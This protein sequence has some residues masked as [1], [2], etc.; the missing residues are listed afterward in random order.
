LEVLKILTLCIASAVTYGIIHDLVTVQICPE[1]FTVAHPPIFQTASLV[2]LAFFWGIAAT[3]WV[4]AILGVILAFAARM[5]RWTKRNARSLIKP[6]WAL[7]LSTGLAA[8]GFGFL[9]WLL[10]SLGL[11]QLAGPM[12]TAIR[13]ELHARFIADIWAHA[14]SYLVGSIGGVTIAVSVWRSRS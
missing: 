14:T 3:W 9:G 2:K 6:T 5:G 10:T 11:V 7:L 8:C 1:Y 12:S 4:G 13:P